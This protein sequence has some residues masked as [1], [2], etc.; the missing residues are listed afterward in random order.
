MITL[1]ICCGSAMDAI[2]AE[3][4]G[5]E[6]IELNSALSLGG[7]TPDIGSLLFCREKVKIPII[8]MV[9]PRAGGF[10]Y[11]TEEYEAMKR[12]AKVMLEA[13]ADGLAFGFLKED[14]TIDKERTV[15]M[16]QLVHSYGK[17]A[18]FHRA[19]D[20]SV[21]LDT[22]IEQLIF[23]GVDRVLTSGG[24]ETAAEGA[25]CLSH[26]Q[27]CYGNEIEI[28]AGSGVRSSNVLSL[29]DETGVKQVHS[30]CRAFAADGTAR[31]NG[32][33]FA[34]TKASEWYAY[35]VVSEEQVRAIKRELTQW[36]G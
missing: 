10:C 13:G 29:L 5:A 15:Q 14:R 4:G 20:A 36:K 31:G 3:R 11:K 21:A 32:V 27:E 23:A 22:A 33:S 28:L 16:V 17:E 6:R 7:L 9:R 26:L 18:V 24:C 2:A 8:A 25:M 34:Y 1:E 19:F 30:S 12:S 35:E